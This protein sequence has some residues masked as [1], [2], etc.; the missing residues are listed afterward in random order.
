MIRQKD[1]FVNGS[2]SFSLARKGLTLASFSFI[3]IAFKH[4]FYRNLEDF[5]GISARIVEAEGE[6]VDH[7]TTTMAPNNIIFLS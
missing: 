3:F 2:M 6:H 1:V 7:F 4:K 5:S